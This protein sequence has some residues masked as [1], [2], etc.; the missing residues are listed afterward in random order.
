MKPETLNW[1]EITNLD[2]VP[3]D[4]PLFIRTKSGFGMGILKDY[5]HEGTIWTSWSKVALAATTPEADIYFK[6]GKEDE[7]SPKWWAKPTVTM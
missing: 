1:N 5:N 6:M 2:A 7:D 4:T 3:R